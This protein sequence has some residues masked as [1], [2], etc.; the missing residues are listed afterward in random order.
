MLSF[1]YG[2]KRLTEYSI[3]TCRVSTLKNSPLSYSTAIDH[4]S[5]FLQIPFF[6]YYRYLLIATRFVSPFH[7]FNRSVVNCFRTSVFTNSVGEFEYIRT[8]KIIYTFVKFPECGFCIIGYYSGLNWNI[9]FAPNLQDIRKTELCSLKHSCFCI[10]IYITYC[11]IRRVLCIFSQWSLY[12]CVSQDL[13]ITSNHSPH[14]DSSHAYDS[15]LPPHTRKA[16]FILC[17]VKCH[18]FRYVFRDFGLS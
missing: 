12:L 14:F 6:R 1:S 16:S 10:Y 5:L 3:I 17:M 7:I 18:R 15:T 8:F 4:S 11:N 13:R 2:S 9:Y